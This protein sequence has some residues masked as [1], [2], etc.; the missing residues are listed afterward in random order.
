M[1][2]VISLLCFLTL[3]SVAE[4][5]NGYMGGIGAGETAGIISGGSGFGIASGAVA[6]APAPTFTGPGDIATGALGFWSC[7]RAYNAAYA[8][9]QSPLCTVVDTTTGLASCTFNVGTN[10]FANLT[11]LVCVGNTVSVTTFCTV[12]HVGC[13]VSEMY[14]QSGN[15]NNVTQA[16]LALMPTLTLSAKNSLPCPAGTGD[17]ATALITSGNVSHAAP[18]SITAVAERTSGGLQYIT[19]NS[20]SARGA[21]G[22]TSSANTVQADNGTSRALTAANNTFHALLSVASGSD[23]LFAVDSSGNT[24]TSSNGTVSLSSVQYFMNY[25]AASAAITA[26]YVCELGIWPSDLNSV[27]TSML[28]NMRSNSVG[29]NF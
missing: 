8:A 24:S 14:D 15:A 16:T 19:G 3:L 6:A 25:N 11:A 1:R 12:T 28:S 13:S 18:Y 21:L 7:G 23:P 26:G 5:Q 17:N 29:W 4:A 2:F 27:Y 10:G 9:A 22:F 20:S